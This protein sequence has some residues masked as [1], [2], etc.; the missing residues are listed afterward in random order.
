MRSGC[1]GVGVTSVYQPI[2][3]VATGVTAGYEALARFNA[4]PER[5]PEKW[6]TAA[7]E[8][9]CHAELEAVAL[10]TALRSRPDLPT[11]TFLTVNVSPDLLLNEQVRSIWRGEGDLTGLVIELTEQAH[12]ESYGALEGDLTAL[13]AAGAMIAIDDAGSGYSGLRHLLELRPAIIKLDRE[14]VEN[15]DLDESKLA[16]A[17]MVGTFAGRIDAWLLAEGIERAGELDAL[18]SLGVPLVQGY[19]LA[20]PGDPWPTLNPEAAQSLVQRQNTP[21]TNS[22]RELI[23][24]VPTATNGEEAAQ[25]F[26]IDHIHTVVMGDADAHPL[27]AH[28]PD[29]IFLGTSERGMRVNVDT[30]V[31][32]ALR[33]AITRDLTHRYE[34]LMCT[35]NAG[36]FLGA[37]RIERLIRA[38][39][40]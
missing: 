33:R 20:R 17:E 4:Y 29:S 40:G 39:I 3:D 28:T 22:V 27:A 1:A 14:L 32:E 8:H 16:L 37:V 30:P 6:F 2:I 15:I 12:I 31:D 5:N 24:V 25:Q 9:G 21:V 7:R 36:R 34:P 38:A 23:E 18:A 19:Y 13:R 10:R 35:D 11:N 26:A